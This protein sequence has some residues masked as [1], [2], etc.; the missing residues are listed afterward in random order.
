MSFLLVVGGCNG[1]ISFLVLNFTFSGKF[2][3]NFSSLGF[4]VF[5]G[6]FLNFGVWICLVEFTSGVLRFR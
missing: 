6:R 3:W 4:D 5:F 1:E 2:F